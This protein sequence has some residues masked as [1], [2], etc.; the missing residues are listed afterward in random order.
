VAH[1]LRH[2]ATKTGRSRVR[3]PMES[4]ESGKRVGLANA[5]RIILSQSSG[6]WELLHSH[7]A[8]QL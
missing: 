2:Y 7:I 5:S 3:F 6:F 8:T 4:L 1:W